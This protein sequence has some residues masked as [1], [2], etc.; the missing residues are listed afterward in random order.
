MEAQVLDQLQTTLTAQGSSAA[1]DKLSEELK[2]RKEYAALFY[3]LLM[4]KRVELGVTP[5]ATGS[6]QDLPL[7]THEAFEEGIRTAART[8]GKLWLDDGDIPQA[9][10]YF[11]M[12]GET[13][14]VARVL[15][16]VQLKEDQDLQPL[17][18]IAFHQ[19]VLPKKG[20]DWILQRYG[21]CSA[22]TTVSAGE[23]P[24]PPEVRHHC[25]KQ[26]IRALHHELMERLK[27]EIQRQQGFA[28]TAT[29]IPELIAGRDWLFADDFYHID[30]SHLNSVVQMSIQLDPC[31]ETKLARELCAY[32]KRLSPRFQ[33]QSDPPFEQPYIDYD[34]YLSVLSGDNVEEGLAHF[35]KKADEADP[36]E[37]GSY[38]AQVLVNL[39]L[40]LGRGKEALA[41]SRKHLAPLGEQRLSCPSFVELCQQIGDWQALAEV[42]R[43]QGNPVNYLA[44]LLAA[45]KNASVEKKPRA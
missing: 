11:R 18:D 21:I 25:V 14:P 24:F 6:N 4:K 17:I 38:P 37:I 40:R 20:F 8:V 16:T 27:V 44:A 32:G 45:S 5:I 2:A 10:A 35:H 23:L 30:L 43:E 12:L 19:G 9:W 13:E 1:L 3:T 26:L 7:A 41:V 22:I 36:E 31:E 42:S 15:E 39:L 28:P 29:T 33:Y 34:V